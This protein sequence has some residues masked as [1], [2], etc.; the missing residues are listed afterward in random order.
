MSPELKGELWTSEF[1]VTI[2]A[3][4]F[5]GFELWAD[6]ITTADMQNLIITPTA[7]VLTQGLKKLVILTKSK[8]KKRKKKNEKEQIRPKPL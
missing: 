1:L 7:Y 4:V 2:G 5:Q 6:F 8:T 3:L